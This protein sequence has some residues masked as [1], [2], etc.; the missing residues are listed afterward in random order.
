MSQQSRITYT[1]MI[2][3]STGA[4]GSGIFWAFFFAT[5]VLFL[6]NFTDSAKLISLPIS[7]GGIVACIIPPV[8]G[9]MSDRSHTRF[10]RRRPYIFLGAIL[11]FFGML[12]LPHLTSWGM[13]ILLVT[14]LAL[15]AYTTETAYWALIPDSAPPE[16]RGATFGT[17]NSLLGAA[18]IVYTL[19]ATRIWDTHPNGTFYLVGSIYVCVMLF[20]IVRIKEPKQPIQVRQRR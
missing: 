16:Q 12:G 10:G 9:Y 5:L 20:T 8:I 6:N 11:V 2:I 13:V 7:L 1:K 3:L 14:L 15:F 17:M 4:S 19:V 18:G